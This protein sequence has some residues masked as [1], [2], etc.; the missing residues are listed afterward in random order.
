VIIG[1]GN[2]AGKVLYVADSGSRADEESGMALSGASERELREWVNSIGLKLDSC[3][4][5]LLYKTYIPGFGRNFKADYKAAEKFKAEI[6]PISPYDILVEE[7]NGINPN[8]IV[9][10]GNHVLRFLTGS[11]NSIKKYRG[12][13]LPTSENLKLSRRFKVIPTFSPQDIFETYS[14]KAITIADYQLKIKPQ[15]HTPDLPVDKSH[16]WICRSATEANA[17]FK[18]LDEYI[19]NTPGAFCTFDIETFA[20]IPTCISICYNGEE[21]ISIPFFAQGMSMADGVLLMH[22]VARFL[23]GPIP[24]VCQNASYEDTICPRFGLKINNIVG[25]TLLA[26]HTLYPEFE[27]NLGFLTSLYTNVPYFKDE[28]KESQNFPPDTTHLL[29]NAKDSLVTHKIHTAQAAELSEENLEAFHTK[30]VMPLFFM[31]R[32]LEGHG[33][34]VS[35]EIRQ[36]KKAKYQYLYDV[37]ILDLQKSVGYEFNPR[38]PDQVGKLVYE[39]LKFP[40]RTKTTNGVTRYNT[41]RKILEEL[42]TFN[43]E[44]NRLG[45]Q[46]R[47][48]LA[49]IV[50]ARRLSK[51][52]EYTE[53]PIH[54]DG[55]WRA[56]WNLAGTETGRTSARKHVD[57]CLIKKGGK[58]KLVNLGRSLQ[59]ITKHG[60]KLEV[61]D[62]EDEVTDSGLFT[63]LGAD[64]REMFVPAPGYEFVEIDQSQAEARHVAVLAEDWD[65]LAILERKTFNTNKHGVE[66]D[67]HTITATWVLEK[68]FEEITKAERQ[69]EGKPT[70]HGGAYDMTPKMMALLYHIPLQHAER[71]LNKFHDKSPKIRSV[72]HREIRNAVQSTRTLYNPFGRRRVFFDKMDRELHKQAYAHIPQGTVSDHQKFAMLRAEPYIESFA[73]FLVEA[74][75]STLAE[76]KIGY[77]EQYAEIMKK[78]LETPIDYRNCT[79]SRNIDLV[80]PVAMEFSQASWGEMEKFKI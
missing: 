23:A 68:P 33:V 69:S 16:I 62:D 25:D 2:S 49:K 18:R 11:A 21:S 27:K 9:A 17:F 40:K 53:T 48:I 70:R 74:H 50:L 22:R 71:A 47:S 39:D 73:R 44:D 66:D 28:G 31:Y 10:M 29:Y 58:W 3:Y 54:P 5:T 55:R 77:R 52:I 15:L 72:F 26:Q 61:E 67:L 79:L 20:G 80:V 13:I 59:T 64:L 8:V 56:S 60:F 32:R 37:N 38:S 63:E 1:H 12:S 42:E 41:S 65:T 75:D 36:K 34:L 51:V 4:R 76:V 14:R 78:E 35:E 7:I 46:G 30:R 57:R 19:R 24:K 43:G 45:S 6:A